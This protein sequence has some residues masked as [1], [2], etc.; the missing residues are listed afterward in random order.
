MTTSDDTGILWSEE[1]LRETAEK[2]PASHSELVAAINLLDAERATSAGLAAE[3]A[4]ERARCDL[5]AE[6]IEHLRNDLTKE[7]AEVERLTGERDGLRAQ[8]DIVEDT[9][10]HLDTFVAR[11][12]A[13]ESRIAELERA[14]SGLAEALVWIMNQPETRICSCRVDRV[15]ELYPEAS[16]CGWCVVRDSIVGGLADPSTSA[17]EG[18]IAGLQEAVAHLGRVPRREFTQDHDVAGFNTALA[19]CVDVVTARIAELS[20]KGE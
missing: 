8:H 17:R 4:G 12:N 7:A 1:S 15:G 2:Y 3:V 10:T 14:A 5:L 9:K 16:K 19:T 18:R 20:G 6:E 13:A 11:A